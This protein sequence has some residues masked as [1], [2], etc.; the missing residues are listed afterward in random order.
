M[1]DPEIT[2]QAVADYYDRN[3]RRFLNL[4]GSGE[5]IAAIHRQVWAPGV[6]NGREAF[7]TLNQMVLHAVQPVLNQPA[8]RLL[9]LGCGI[10]GTTTWIASRLGVETIGITLSAQQAIQAHRRAERLGQAAHTRFLQGDFQHLPEIETCSAAWAIEAYLHATEPERFFREAA[11]VIQPGGR[12]VIADDFLAAQ[13]SA[14]SEA[15]R[16]LADFSSGW[17][18]PN[19]APVSQALSMAQQAGFSLLQDTDLSPYLKTVPGWVVRVGMAILRMPVNS[20]F[21]QSLRGSTALQE[22]VRRGWTQ[23]HLLIWERRS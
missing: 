2:P 13:V 15:A 18:V 5:D 19:L 8:A 12:L 3:T 10:G 20:V 14:G 11:R 1:P 6:R 22:C 16:W 23:Y 17:H 21:W 9:D 4:F 7:E